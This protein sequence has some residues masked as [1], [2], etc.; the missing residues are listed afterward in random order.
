MIFSTQN[1]H[2]KL[3]ESCKIKFPILAQNIWY[4]PLTETILHLSGGFTTL[5]FVNAIQIYEHPALVKAIYYNTAHSRFY[6]PT[7]SL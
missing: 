7:G 2:I 5:K 6:Y 4:S 3:I 1:T